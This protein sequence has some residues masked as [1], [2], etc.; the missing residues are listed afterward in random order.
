MSF[1]F[2]SFSAPAPQ[3]AHFVPGGTSSAT[4]LVQL[5]GGR[6][7]VI[8]AADLIALRGYSR[9]LAGTQGADDA[10]P[11]EVDEASLID[12]LDQ[13]EHADKEAFSETGWDRLRRYAAE[14]ANLRGLMGEPLADLIGAIERTIGVDVEATV[15]DLR[16]GSPP[17]S[18]LDQFT[19]VAHSFSGGAG[20]ESAE[21]FLEY[22]EAAEEA[23]RPVPALAPRIVLHP[24]AERRPDDDRL[25]GQGHPD[26]I[27][28]DLDELRDLGATHVLLDTHRDR[29]RSATTTRQGS[30]R[31]AA[32][33]LVESSV[34]WPSTPRQGLPGVSN[35]SRRA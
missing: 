11:D 15:R 19:G 32:S 28:A 6:R 13:I 18:A 14:L 35:A 17:R 9:R 25:A 12:A 30:G 23:D 22:L 8:G 16:R 20:T 4:D 29:R 31:R 27:R 5:L 21:A 2:S 26:Q 7:W 10:D 24:T 34:A 1:S 33:R 3:P